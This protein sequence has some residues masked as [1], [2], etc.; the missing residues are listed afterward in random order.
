MTDITLDEE[1]S[2]KTAPK[3]GFNEMEKNYVTI[4]TQH[5]TSIQERAS[6]LRISGGSHG[7]EL[8]GVSGPREERG[9]ALLRPTLS[10]MAV[11][12]G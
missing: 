1:D 6:V 4:T 10:K 3:A 2:G 9:N 12:S 5:Q 11:L 7:K 8:R